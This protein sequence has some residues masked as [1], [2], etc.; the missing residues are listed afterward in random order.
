MCWNETCST[1]PIYLFRDQKNAVASQIAVAPSVNVMASS[2]KSVVTSVEEIAPVGNDCSGVM[3]STPHEEFSPILH[4]YSNDSTTST[5]S[6]VT[7]SGCVDEEEP[8]PV[9]FKRPREDSIA[10]TDVE[11]VTP[12]RSWSSEDLAM[13]SLS[14]ASPLI[15]PPNGGNTAA[16]AVV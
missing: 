4:V 6:H 14:A 12:E 5:Q 13:K 3:K 15:L 11:G 16:T 7:F 9:G 1:S 10:T 2:D 8:L